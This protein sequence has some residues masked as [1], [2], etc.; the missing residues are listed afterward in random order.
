MKKNKKNTP[1]GGRPDSGGNEKRAVELV[2]LIIPAVILFSLAALTLFQPSRPTVSEKENRML[3]S[4]P[5][6]SWEALA[7]GSFFAEVSAFIGDTF[8]QRE[9]LIDLSRLMDGAMGVEYVIDGVGYVI[10]GPTPAGETTDEETAY[11]PVPPA[12]ETSEPAAETVNS[13]T[14]AVDPPVSGDIPDD[15]LPEDVSRNPEDTLAEPETEPETTEPQPAYLS[16]GVSCGSL[17]VKLGGS[18]IL[19]ATVET[20]KI[21]EREP[22]VW[23]VSDP[24]LL[25]LTP[26]GDSVALFALREGTAEVIASCGGLSSSCTVTVAKAAVQTVEDTANAEN[27]GSGVFVYNGSGYTTIDYVDKTLCNLAKAYSALLLRYRDLFPGT[28]VSMVVA[29]Y[30]T[31]RV[32]AGKVSAA[33][34]DQ[35]E[36]LAIMEQNYDP[37]INFVN[38]YDLIYAHRDENVYFRS[39]NH[40]T[41]L[42]AYYA[43]VAYMESIGEQPSP[44]TAFSHT[45]A[46]ERML[47]WYYSAYGN[48]MKFYDRLEYWSTKKT[49][50]MTIT[51]DSSLGWKPRTYS[52]MFLDGNKQYTIHLR[53]DQPL[54]VVRVPDNPQDRKALV[55]KDSFGNAFAPYLA[56]TYGTVVVVDPREYFKAFGESQ[57]LQNSF[58]DYGF[59]DIIFVVNIQMANSAY[60]VNHWFYPLI[61]IN[62]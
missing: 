55:V 22:V 58:K 2:C 17:D 10:G 35:R 62:P 44:L 21:D 6:F 33:G 12:P 60:W 15:T 39:D 31:M 23:S 27:V 42:A 8:W 57:T 3:T 29:P 4:F 1:S 19:T 28:R 24:H 34:R 53:G 49:L 13:E 5:E 37:E 56:E 48:R 52:S 47:G 14:T 40:W 38:C 50:S 18:G 61:G 20:Y 32:D 30:G 46:T 11:I 25:T 45:V 36:M 54:T 9:K 16:V 59:T 51:F 43:W 26:D 7:D 41:G